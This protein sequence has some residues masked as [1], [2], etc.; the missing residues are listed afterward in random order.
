MAGKGGKPTG[1]IRQSQ[2]VSTFGPGSMVDLPNHA[3]IVGG[4]EHWH[5]EKRPIY[6]DRLAARVAEILDVDEVKMYAPPVDS[7]DPSAPRT[8]ITAFMFPQWF[9]AQEEVEVDGFRS[10]PLVH[11]NGLVKGK[12]LT[13]DKRKIPVV[14]IRI[15]QACPNGHISDVNWRAFVHRSY[16]DPCKGQ[17]WLD[18]GGTSGDLADIHVRCQS[19][20]KR[21]SLADA[22]VP[23][24]HVLGSCNGERPWLGPAARESCIDENTGKPH[25]NR[26]LVRSASNAY[27]S[28][29][30]GVIHIPDKDQKLR[31]AVDP[32]YEDH[33]QYAESIEDVKRER[34]RQKVASHIQGFDDAAVWAEVQRRRGNLEAPRR[35]IKQ[36]EIETLLSASELG[37]DRLEG[38]FYAAARPLDDLPAILEPLVERIVLVH[39]LR[40]VTAQVG[41][42][43]FEAQMP[44]IDGELDLAVKRAAL[45]MDPLWVPASENRGEGIFIAFKPSAIK[46]WLSR[47]EVK[48]RYRRL[49]AG[50]R[51]W[52][53]G[54]GNPA[55]QFPGA[56]YVML[57]SL[58]HLLVTQVSLECGYAASSIRERVYAGHCGYGI[59]LHTGTP[60]AEGTLGGLIEVGRSIEH[61]LLAALEMGRLCSNDPV[62]AG[63]DPADK[64]EERF[65]HGAACH[66]CLLIAE[67]SCERRNELLDRALVVPTVST[68]GAA[69]F[70]G[71]YEQAAYESST[72]WSRTSHD[73]GEG[74]DL[75]DF[76]PRWHP[77]VA[78]LDAADGVTVE[79]G[80]EASSDGRVVGPYLA[81]VRCRGAAVHLVDDG[82]ADAAK[83]V[84]TLEAAGARTIRVRPNTEAAEI[85]AAAGCA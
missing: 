21:R 75:D 58:S 49:D 32:V 62:C 16:E 40:E 39:R 45:S 17:L 7:Q 19:C 13:E 22:K 1:E 66:G 65:L 25:P 50:F 26:L 77:L 4:L 34:K 67:T 8:G 83:V 20:K 76:D 71:D 42:T 15:V 60:G 28:Q 27:F 24:A 63:H 78:A 41:F 11:W 51:A 85:L 14:P 80:G 64:F 73:E 47:A 31:E 70:S 2:I 36:A 56:A 57:H 29:N 5:G 3:V 12:Y 6:E 72:R 84:S 43:R 35:S 46:R 44:D 23:K 55:L 9:V 38:D 59:L 33:L 68:P 18:E 48:D 10:R 52:A 61:H 81:V 53:T 54:K 82:D 37:A 30:L 74:L 69:F 79:L